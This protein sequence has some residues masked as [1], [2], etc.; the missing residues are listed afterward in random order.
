M[1]AI[2]NSRCDEQP[3]PVVDACGFPFP[4]LHFST[5]IGINSWTRKFNSLQHQS[6]MFRLYCNI[7]SPISSSII[8]K[9]RKIDGTA[10]WS[11]CWQSRSHPAGLNEKL[12][13]P[14]VRFEASSLPPRS[15]I[16]IYRFFHVSWQGQTRMYDSK[17]DGPSGARRILTDHSKENRSE[18]TG[19][20]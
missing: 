16:L 15:L 8:A 17:S 12:K 3:F 2:H 19:C 5:R 13:R 9:G 11:N 18:C 10:R 6:F 1:A 7:R 4:I 20:V 14:G